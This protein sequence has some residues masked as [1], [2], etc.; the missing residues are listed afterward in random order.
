MPEEVP[1]LV[2]YGLLLLVRGFLPVCEVVLGHPA[3]LV[4]PRRAGYLVRDSP[5]F[6]ATSASGR[7]TP[8]APGASG[9]WAGDGGRDGTRG[10]KVKSVTR[11]SEGGKGRPRASPGV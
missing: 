1:D 11:G 4:R 2:M 6:S 7:A 5:M 8:A 3:T 10:G 9:G